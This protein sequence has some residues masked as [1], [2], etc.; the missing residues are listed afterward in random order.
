M[1]TLCLNIVL[2]VMKAGFI[3]GGTNMT[4]EDHGVEEGTNN[5]CLQFS[6]TIKRTFED[7]ASC[8]TKAQRISALVVE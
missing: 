8:P 1:S 5:K 2:T 3:S 7:R 4:L 6:N